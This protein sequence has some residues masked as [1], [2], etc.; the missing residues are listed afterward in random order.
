MP[1]GVGVGQV[2]GLVRE[3]RGVE[4]SAPRV[5][6]SGPDP[7]DLAAALAAG[8]DRSAVSVGGNPAAVAIA[9]RLVDGDP[10]ERER[11]V[12]RQLVKE[13][14]PVVVVRRGGSAR[15][16]HVLAGDVVELEVE[17]ITGVAVAIA[18]AAGA[19][20]PGLAARLPILRAPVAARLVAHTAC[21]NAALAASSRAAP[22]LPLLTLAQARMLFLLRAARGDVLPRDPEGLLRAIGPYLVAALGTGV[23]ARAVVRRLPVRGSII[24]A[25]IAYGGTRALGTA[26]RRL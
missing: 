20:G 11:R 21:A 16:P 12:L 19:D 2:V 26:L 22:Q 23:G 9:V 15:M 17:G 14:T 10:D 3:V 13:P 7:E 6:I 8:G 1:A 18:R 4:R 24:R 5:V 25:A